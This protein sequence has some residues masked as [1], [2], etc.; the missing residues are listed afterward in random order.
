MAVR[1]AIS[2]SSARGVPFQS[3]SPFQQGEG[4][5]PEQPEYRK[6]G[7]VGTGG[8]IRWAECTSHGLDKGPRESLAC[9]GLQLPDGDNGSPTPSKTLD[10]TP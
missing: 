7:N 5:E 3:S 8:P 9:L 2:R 1:V 6:P 4:V 10:G